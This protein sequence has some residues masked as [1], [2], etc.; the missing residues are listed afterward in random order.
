MTEINPAQADRMLDELTAIVAQA[1]RRVR[2]MSPFTVER[3][4]KS[5]GSHVTGA[6]E[7]SQ[8]VVLAGL[9]QVCP[10]IPALSEESIAGAPAPPKDGSFIIID[11]LDGTRDYLDGRD[12]FA[13]CLAVITHGE[14]VAGIIAAPMR[15]ILW[16]GVVGLRAERLRLA[17]GDVADPQPIHTRQWPKQNAIA[18]VSR[19]HLDRET[20]TMLDR[21]AIERHPSGSAIKFCLVAE[22]SADIYPRLA[23]TSEWDVAAGHALLLAAGGRLTTSQGKDITYGHADA[24]Y[25]V[26]AFIAWGDSNK[27]AQ[28]EP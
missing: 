3:R 18:V 11:P 27:A 1:A 2:E 12:E 19:S 9:K 14:P 26:P 16:R 8:A 22:G 17:S 20:E 15:G 7:T 13:I 21:L 28:F 23:P 4:L 25:R 10:S 5:D 6:D 24:N